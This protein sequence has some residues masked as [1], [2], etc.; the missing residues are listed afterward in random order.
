MNFGMV[1]LDAGQRRFQDYVGDVLD[2]IVTDEVRDKLRRTGELFDEQMIAA[3]GAKGLAQPDWPV[4]DGGSGLDPLRL[5]IFDLELL[6]RGISSIGG[7]MIWRA[8]AAYGAPDLVAELKPKVAAG[9]VHFCAGFT[10]PDGGSDIAAA[11]VRAVRDGDEWVINGSK[12]FTTSAHQ[13]QYV[14]LITRTDPAQPKHRGLT[15]FL[16]PLSTP[17]IEIRPVHT[18]GGERTNIV[19]YGDVR[20]PDRYRLGRVNDGWTVLRGPLDA[21]HDFA[22]QHDGLADTFGRQMMRRSPI[23]RSFDAAL[24]WARTARRPDG[25]HPIDDPAVRTRLGRVAADLEWAQ[26]AEGPLGR[27]ASSVAM[28]RCSAELVDL[29]GVEALLPYGAD[30]TVGAGAVDDAHR[31]AQGAATYG[32]TVE[33]FREMIAQHVLGLPRAQRPGSKAFI[34]SGRETAGTVIR[35]TNRDLKKNRTFS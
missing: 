6:R 12:I 17:G 33:V 28:T 30:G 14:F 5:R 7:D 35:L 24:A 11:K 20:I 3:L 26:C 29:V 34:G 23:F 13:S 32:G 2:E 27:V 22:Q 4:E 1:E 15:M 31:F 8:V 25:T 9:T 10:E 19:Y 16:V 21:E 18:F